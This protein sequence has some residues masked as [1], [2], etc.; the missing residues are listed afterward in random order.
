MKELNKKQNFTDNTYS[1]AKGLQ[2]TN[3]AKSYFEDL[4]LGTN[5]EVKMLFG[6][7]ILRCDWILNN[8]KHR[9]GADTTK[10]F[11]EE[12]K[13]PLAFDSIMDKLIKLDSS[14]RELLEGILNAMINGETIKV[15]DDELSKY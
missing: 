10:I 8:I 2:L 6:N 15:M 1:L 14:Q 3:M 5:G 9:L 4:R 13:D 12:M 11:L 7:I